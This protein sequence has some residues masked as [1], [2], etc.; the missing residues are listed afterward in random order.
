MQLLDIRS[1]PTAADRWVFIHGKGSFMLRT[2]PATWIESPGF[3][4]S[5]PP[6][7]RFRAAGG[8]DLSMRT[9]DSS[10]DTFNRMRPAFADTD[11]RTSEQR[12]IA[13]AEFINQI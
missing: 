10:C 4:Q 2:W 11:P 12:S 7:T 3:S 5:I 8:K 9:H 6:W 13:L 1:K